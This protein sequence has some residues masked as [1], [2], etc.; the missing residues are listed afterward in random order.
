[1]IVAKLNKHDV[2]QYVSL[3][4]FD[5]PSPNPH[6][7]PILYIIHS[8]LSFSPLSLPLSPPTPFPSP[9]PTLSSAHG[10]C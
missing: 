9:S 10:N 1:M 7:I 5:I 4:V 2:C 3:P 8:F 6:S